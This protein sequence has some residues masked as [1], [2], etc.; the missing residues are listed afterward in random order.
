[1]RLLRLTTLVLLTGLAF[2]ACSSPVAPDSCAEV[3]T[4]GFPTS[5][6]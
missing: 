3:E 2:T 1:M 5:G 6:S 4:C